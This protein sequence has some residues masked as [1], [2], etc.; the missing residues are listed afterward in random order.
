MSDRAWQVV[1]RRSTAGEF[2]ALAIPQP[3]VPEIWVHEITR[4]ALVLGSTQ[5]DDEIVD[6]EACDRAGV[7]VVRRRSGGGA[8]LLIP[9]Q[10]TWVDVLLPA[11]HR[12][13]S[14]DVHRPMV[15]LG[16]A[17]STAF[18]AAG[19]PDT[20]V[21]EGAMAATEY[22]RL[23]CFDGMGPGELSIGGAKLVGISQR[24]VRAAARLQCCWYSWYDPGALTALL[25]D[26]PRTQRLNPVAVVDDLV[27]ASV[28]DDLAAAL[29]I[30]S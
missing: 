16:R 13:W 17:L 23:I 12:A 18:A 4:P 15:W 24:R 30:A 6:A 7:D 27:S 22:S 25:A 11:G 19:A 2:H 14:D 1:R 9:G 10:V 26:G 21:H 8:V 3:A 29:D 28:V 5:R 20:T